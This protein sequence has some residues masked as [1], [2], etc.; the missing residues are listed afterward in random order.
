M[1]AGAVTTQELTAVISLP[2]AVGGAPSGQG[3]GSGGTRKRKSTLA[4]PGDQEEARADADALSRFGPPP[5]L[6]CQWALEIGRPRG[7][8]KCRPSARSAACR[9]GSGTGCRLTVCGGRRGSHAPKNHSL[10]AGV[11]SKLILLAR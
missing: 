3:R 8:R 4:N 1:A 2:T 10:W 6:A 5:E 9:R 11:V 7:G